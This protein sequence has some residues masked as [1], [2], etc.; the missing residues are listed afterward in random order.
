MLLL[1]SLLKLGRIYK[2]HCFSQE[3]QIIPCLLP[4]IPLDH[5]IVFQHTDTYLQSEHSHPHPSG[6]QTN[7]IRAHNSLHQGVLSNPTD[8]FPFLT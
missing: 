1:A 3:T 5:E 7:N 6:F 8:D 2:G 4:K